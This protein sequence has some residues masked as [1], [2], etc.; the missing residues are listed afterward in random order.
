MSAGAVA[1]RLP[2]AG[3]DVATT[4]TEEHWRQR[5]SEH[6]H[7]EMGWFQA[8]PEPSLALVTAHT[9]AGGHVLDV[10][11][12]ASLLVDRLLERGYA[13]SVLDLAAP[14]LAAAQERLGERA[15]E[16]EWVHGDVTRVRLD[17][18]CDTWH[19]RA[20]LHFLLEDAERAAY[21]AT[22]RAH[23]RTGGHAVIGTFGPDG[24]TTCSGLPVRRH[25]VGDL[26]DLLGDGFEEV[27]SRAVV[28]RTPGGGEQAFTFAVFVRR[29]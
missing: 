14:A 20:V 10:G 21:V 8:E 4:S 28:H 25:D 23:L 3:Q 13:V 24:P 17:R 11:G 15:T 16:V 6:D 2:A 22:L 26:A 5:W 19:D 27:A 29:D 1:C 18:R 7:D 12:G 9:P